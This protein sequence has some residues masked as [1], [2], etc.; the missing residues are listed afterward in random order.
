[1]SDILFR[2]KN[3]I[4]SYRT[5]G[6]LVHGDRVLL[7]KPSNSGDYAFPGGHIAFGETTAE[8]LIREFKE[9]MGADIEVTELKW[10]EE[11]F[12]SW[13]DKPCH[14]ISLSYLVRLKDTAQIPLDGR[15]ISEEYR[16]NDDNAIYFYW[17]PL[18]EVKNI[19][20]YPANAA[21]LLL[22]LDDGVKHFVY[23][24]G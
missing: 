4:F 16:E 13:G 9:E 10:V 7:Q 8:T 18:D 12:F 14:Q 11:N 1:M 2:T 20:V 23:R 15:F 5:A 19:N 6:I 22:K 3:Y 17:I 24:E 21:E